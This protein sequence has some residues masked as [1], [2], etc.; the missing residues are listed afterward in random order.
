[1]SFQRSLILGTLGALALAAGCSR[2]LGIEDAE[3]DPTYSRDCLSAERSDGGSTSTPIQTFGLNPA[4]AGSGGNAGAVASAG[5]GG[6]SSGAGG[7][8]G[9]GG[10][11]TGAAGSS[12]VASAGAA[13][14]ASMTTDPI[15]AR[16]S[17]LCLD[18]CDTVGTACTGKNQQY[19]TQI[20]CLAVCEQ[21]QPGNPG[22][23]S[24]NTVE[25][26]LGLADQALRTGEPSNYCYAAGPGGA[27]VCGS[28]CEGFCTMMTQK[29]TQMGTFSQCVNSCLLVPDLS[30][31]PTNLRYDSSQQSGNS[32]QCRL[33]HVS[34]ASVDPVG[35]CVHAAGQTP[36]SN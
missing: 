33:F 7:S 1:M 36:C 19:A 13:G 9:A 31:A 22:A 16:A 32:L 27:G 11:S 17:Q 6:S 10:S 4:S 8:G 34:A 25:C 12:M 23:T 35:H 15:L 20:A 21:L 18:Y 14:S 5:A 30:Q 28:D 29:C 3:C 26:R 2:I 24:G